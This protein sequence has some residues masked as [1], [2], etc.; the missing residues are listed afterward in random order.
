MIVLFLPSDTGFPFMLV[1]YKFL[2]KLSDLYLV[3]Q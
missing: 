2:L 3:K 1:I